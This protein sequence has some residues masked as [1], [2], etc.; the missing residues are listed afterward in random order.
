MLTIKPIPKEH[1][2]RFVEMA[3][4]A[5][6]VMKANTEEEK[7]KLRERYEKRNADPRI[8]MWGAYDGDTLLG[9]MRFFDFTMNLRGAKILCGGGGMLAVDL[10]HKKEH[11]AR[12]LV[13]FWL[14]HYRQNEAPMAMLWPFRPDFY[15]QMGFGYGAKLDQYRVKPEHFPSHGHKKRV[16]LL[17]RAD[18]PALCACYNRYADGITGMV[19]E[20]ELAWQV[21]FDMFPQWR[22][23]GYEEQGRLLG[24]IIFEFEPAQ[25]PTFVNNNMRVH[26]LVYE[27]PDALHGLM[28]FLH[29]QADQVNR[30]LISTNDEYFHFLL[31]DVR[32]GTDNLVEIYHES[33]VS[34]VGVMYRV[35]DLPSVF[36]ALRDHNFNDQS[37]ALKITLRDSFIPENEG[38]TLVRFA[39]GRVTVE[40]SGDPEAEITLDVADL[41]SLLI[42]SVSF[43]A[44]HRLGLVQISDAQCLKT[45][46]RI[47]ATDSKPSCH[48]MF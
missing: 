48:T 11:V 4:N 13:R 6:P 25:P 26:R 19:V 23:A 37:C 47:F 2:D 42:G 10:A 9:G 45:V 34:G 8:S 21:Q 43:Q 44:L 36:V 40:P 20:S 29:S 14:N 18:I 3:A 1:T 38:N 32:N 28:S 27:T 7:K 12:D 39:G 16:R 17:G 33:H 24:Y 35:I 22:M 30:V 46:H 31:G 5:Y 15:K 41:S